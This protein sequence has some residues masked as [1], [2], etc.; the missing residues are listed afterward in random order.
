MHP[1]L[2]PIFPAKLAAASAALWCAG[3]LAAAI[4]HFSQNSAP[5]PAP[6]DPPQPFAVVVRTIPMIPEM[7][8]DDRWQAPAP[9]MQQAGIA[10]ED[11]PIPDHPKPAKIKPKHVERHAESRGNICTRH[12][13][14]KVITRGGKS[15]RCRR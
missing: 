14:R 12:H 2:H 10:E 1:P 5:L 4:G 7:P 6:A 9:A 11:K 13:M 8:F 15:W 3:W